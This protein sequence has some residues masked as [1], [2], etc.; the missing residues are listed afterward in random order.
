MLLANLAAHTT[1]LGLRPLDHRLSPKLP[2]LFDEQG[3]DFIG[4][5]RRSLL[6]LG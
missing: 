2:H 6:P 5:P 4:R 3:F 1:G